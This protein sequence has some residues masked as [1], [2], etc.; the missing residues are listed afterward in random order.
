MKNFIFSDNF[1]EIICIIPI[2]SSPVPFLPPP[3][4]PSPTLLPLSPAPVPLHVHPLTFVLVKISICM[5]NFYCVEIV[6]EISSV[7]HSQ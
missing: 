6:Y 1:H 4:P 3:L 7:A 5:Y 2:P